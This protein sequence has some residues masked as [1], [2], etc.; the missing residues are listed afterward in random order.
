MKN[1][2]KKGVEVILVSGRADNNGVCNM[3]R[4]HPSF[5]S[6]SCIYLNKLIFNHYNLWEKFDM[7]IHRKCWKDFNFRLKIVNN[8]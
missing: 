7:A 1:M 3:I 5:Y 6:L 8:R 2:K 4:T